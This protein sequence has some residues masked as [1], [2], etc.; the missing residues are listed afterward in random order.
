MNDFLQTALTLPTLLYSIA[1]AVCVLYWLLAATGLV[2]ADGPEGLFGGDAEGD[3]DASGVAAM[4]AKLGLAGV[5]V[6]IV[7]TVLA[8]VG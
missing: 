2:D 1:L 6:M 8:L 7:L 3:G 4:L 5:P